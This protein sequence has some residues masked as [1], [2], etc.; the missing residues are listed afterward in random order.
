[1]EE[2]TIAKLEIWPL[3]IAMRRPI[4]NSY[5]SISV[6]ECILVKAVLSN[7]VYGW[8]EAAPEFSITRETWQTAFDIL[9]HEIKPRVVGKAFLKFEE[10]LREIDRAINGNPTAKAAFDI[11]GHDALAR[12]AKLPLN[13]LLGRTGDRLETTVTVGLEKEQETSR[14]ALMLLAEG[15]TRLKIKIGGTADSDVNRIRLVREELGYGFSIVVDANQA[16]SKRQAI[17]VLKRL[18]K[19]EI[20]FCEQPVSSRN[21]DDLATVS[22]WSSIPIMADESVFTPR[23]ALEVV[24]HKAADMINIKLMKSGG[25]SAARRIAAIAEAAEMPCMVGCMTETKVGIA[26]GCHFATSQPIVK[27]A[28]LDGHTLLT[29]DPV[30]GGVQIA[31]SQERILEGSG[32]ALEVQES[33][34]ETLRLDPSTS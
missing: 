21:L 5:G 33:K 4:K 8:G 14:Q 23:D 26:A 3:R 15:V 24:R 27:Y 29:Q 2:L 17:N 7:G 6:H 19:Y 9:Q 12:H 10:L 25:I 1:M 11:A 31:G 20:D 16:F 22:R 13:G 18:E 32:L 30:L 34:L 28:D